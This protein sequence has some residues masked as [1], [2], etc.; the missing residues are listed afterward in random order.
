[1]NE[2]EPSKLLAAQAAAALVEKGMAIGLGSGTTAA[3]IVRQLGRRVREE[4]LEFVG[5]VHQPATSDLAWSVGIVLVAS[6]DEISMLDLNLDGADEVDPQFRMIKGRGGA[7][8]REKIV[9]STARHRVTVDHRGQAGRVILR[10]SR[11]RCRWKSAPVWPASHTEARLARLGASTE[12]R[13]Q[14]GPTAP[15]SRPDGG[16]VGPSSTAA[17]P[18]STIP[19]GGLDARLRQAVA[20]ACSRPGLLPTDSATCSSSAIPTTSRWSRSSRP[21]VS[22][23]LDRSS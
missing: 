6:L 16:H 20:S 21:C 23:R 3:E 10:A 11:C 1:M 22:P 12:L 8:L 13:P 9:V 14:N 2:I 7:L 17:S 15:R 4:G 19:Q 5:G 18:A